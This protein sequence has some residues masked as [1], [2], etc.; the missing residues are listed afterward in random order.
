[1]MMKALFSKKILATAVLSLFASAGATAA[2]YN[3]FD[4]KPANST[5]AAFTAD[6]IIGGYTEVITFTP[7]DPLNPAGNG[8]FNVSL[9]WTADQFYLG[10]PRVPPSTTSRINI[11]YGIYALYTA[12]GNFTR[13]GAVTTFN[14]IEGSGSLNVYLDNNVDTTY[15]NPAVGG[16]AFNLSAAG[17]DVLLA[18]GN[19][20]AGQGKLD[21]GLTTC[22]SSG[23]SQ[24][25]PI[26][27]GSFGSTTSFN[28]TNDP[29]MF[30]GVD[31]FVRP[32]PFY[33][34]SF[35]AG[36]LNRFTPTGTQTIDGSMDVTFGDVPEPASLG[37]LGLGLLGLSAA[38]R[39]KQPK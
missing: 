6:R 1:M 19:P 8:T 4:V 33:N 21:L 28:L 29:T 9:I 38:R 10:G 25:N 11:D 37:L 23:N 22:N 14:F 34:L 3:T 31:F 26:N 27:C 16:A 17:D 13:N 39:R 18:T 30:D 20:L 35:Q 12:S 24:G 32:N 36:Q 2:T 15:T 7:S 5:R